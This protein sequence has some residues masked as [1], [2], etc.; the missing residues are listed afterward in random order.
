[1]KR[2]RFLSGAVYQCVP[3]PIIYEAGSIHDMRDDLADR[4]IRRGVAVLVP[5]APFRQVPLAPE[6]VAELSGK[7]ISFAALVTAPD[8]GGPIVS[9]KSEVDEPADQAYA[10][11]SDSV[12][13][14]YPPQSEAPAESS[15]SPFAGLDPASFLPK[16]SRG[17][18][19]G[20]R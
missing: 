5:P 8:E 19:R 1:M 6:P 10:S 18:R 4:W 13:T 9:T 2:I 14:I 16:P 15:E 3:G 7:P 12:L 20:K 11:V 17:G